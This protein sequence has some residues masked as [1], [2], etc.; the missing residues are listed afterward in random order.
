MAQGEFNEKATY[1]R[2]QHVQSMQRKR[3]VHIDR[4]RAAMAKN[5]ITGGVT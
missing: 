4:R 2:Q 5:V 1:A 3:D